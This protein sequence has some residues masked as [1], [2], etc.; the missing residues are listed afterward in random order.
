MIESYKKVLE[1]ESV[2]ELKIEQ[3]K[4]ALEKIRKILYQDKDFIL[5]KL[6]S[7][8]K[9]E[10][11]ISYFKY[12]IIDIDNNVIDILVKENSKIYKENIEGKEFI[13]LNGEEL[14]DNRIFNNEDEIIIVDI[15][16]DK[17]LLNLGYLC[18]SLNYNF[19]SYSESI[20]EKL[21]TFIDYVINKNICKK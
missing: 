18:D 17:E 2:V 6:I 15:N 12:K 3:D 20:K 10:L 19:L 5:D 1:M 8:L 14:I 13:N 9:Q 21:S 16:F 7:Y 4:K 11:N